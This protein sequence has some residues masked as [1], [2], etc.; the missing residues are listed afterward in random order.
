[1]GVYGILEIR[2]TAAHYMAVDCRRLAVG[3]W[4]SAVGRGGRHDDSGGA[5]GRAHAK[6]RCTDRRHRIGTYSL[7]IT[8]TLS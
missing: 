7:P 4:Q 2:A 3:G 8:Y 1:M 5:A 6:R